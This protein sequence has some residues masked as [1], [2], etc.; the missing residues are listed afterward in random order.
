MPLKEIV[1]FDH[2]LTWVMEE[3]MQRASH[4]VVADGKVWLIDP[5]DVPEAIA[6]AEALGEIAGV[7]QLLDRH[8]RACKALAERYGVP[9]HKLPPAGPLEGTPFEVVQL[10]EKKAW[11]ERALWWPEA[12]TLIVAELVGTNHYYALSGE[13]GVHVML[14]ASKVTVGE[15]L[16][17]EHL[18]MGHGAPLHHDVPAQLARAYA[19]RKRDLVLLPKGLR[20]F[21]GKQ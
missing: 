15:D 10:I 6:E 7:I 20:A 16:P 5:V 4:A 17:V 19:R 18:L 14:R 8:P 3:W 13:L 1:R 11:R 12:R 2:G 9:L 21:V